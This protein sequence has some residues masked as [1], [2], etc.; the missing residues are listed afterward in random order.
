[1][2]LPFAIPPA[3]DFAF[4]VVTL[5]LNSIDLVALVQHYPPGNSKQ[6]LEHFAQLPGGQSA[7]A[8]AVCARLGWRARYIGSFG[9][10]DLGAAGRRSL[11]EEGVDVE[12]SWNVTGATSQFA[13]IIV[14]ATNGERTVLWNRHS[15]LAIDPDQVSCE[16][17]VSGRMLLVDCHETAAAARAARYARA[18][19]I[20][21]VVDVEKVREGISS[22]LTE[23]DA[24]IAAQAFPTALTGYAEPGRALAAIAKEFHTPLVAVTLGHEGSLA[25]C[26]GREIRTPAF[27]VP[28]VDTTGAG[29]AFHGGFVAACL[30][31]PDAP[32]A[33]I[34]RYANAVA[35]LN[36]RRLGARGGMPTP[37]EV[38]ALL[39]AQSR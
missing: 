38:E 3:A 14:D 28:C 19:R 21:T 33:D 36:C 13:V 4:D 39:A 23:I 37:A 11:T 31:A 1:V 8:A 27:D 35:A 10:D 17:V 24:I 7:T 16:A 29:D 18:A 6:R 22:L 26:Q 15:G 32:V 12:A 30:Q 2:R 9:D 25:L 5:G 20:P 34:M